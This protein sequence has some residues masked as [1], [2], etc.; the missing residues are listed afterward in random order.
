[1]IG[2]LKLTTH[3]KRPVYVVIDHIVAWSPQLL[4]QDGTRIIVTNIGH[5]TWHDR[6]L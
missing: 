2:I 5:Y 3:D 6:L 4:S 1:M